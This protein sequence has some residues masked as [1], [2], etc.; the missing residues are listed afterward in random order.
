MILQSIEVSFKKKG[1]HI[2]SFEFDEVVNLT[3]LISSNYQMNT[4]DNF[5]CK[6]FLIKPLK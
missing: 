4:N 2:R 5:I 6:R 1:S 3:M